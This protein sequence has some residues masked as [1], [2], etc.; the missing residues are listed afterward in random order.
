MVFGIDAL[1]GKTIL[2]LTVDQSAEG[3]AV[4][5]RGGEILQKKGQCFGHVRYVL[6]FIFQTYSDVDILVVSQ[7]PLTPEKKSVSS[8]SLLCGLLVVRDFDLNFL[9][10]K[11]QLSVG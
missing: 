10:L 3:Q 4:T 6:G 2:V 7:L 5:P 11:S 8:R 9:N 1:V